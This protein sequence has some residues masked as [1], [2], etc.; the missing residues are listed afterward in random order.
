LERDPSHAVIEKASAD[1]LKVIRPNERFIFDA[2]QASSVIMSFKDYLSRALGDPPAI[3]PPFI[4]VAGLGEPLARR[5]GYGPGDIKD[6]N[7][8]FVEMLHAP[9]QSYGRGGEEISSFYVKRSR[10]ITF[11]GELNLTGARGEP[12]S[13]SSFG[14]HSSSENVASVPNNSIQFNSDPE[15]N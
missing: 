11:F 6:L 9:L 4:T 13:N 2:N 1:V 15:L 12:P 8:L 10:H 14:A 7:Y 3:V 5:C